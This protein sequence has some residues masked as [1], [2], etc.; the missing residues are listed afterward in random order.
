MALLKFFVIYAIMASQLDSVRSY[1]YYRG[2]KYDRKLEKFQLVITPPAFRKKYIG[3]LH[4]KGVKVIAS[5]EKTDSL[6]VYHTLIDEQGFD[7]FFFVLTPS[8][9][10]FLKAVRDSFPQAVIVMSLSTDSLAPIEIEPF[11]D[12]M[13]GYLWRL[14]STK[15]EG[16]RFVLDPDTAR[17]RKKEYLAVNILNRLRKKRKRFAVFAFDVL[18]VADSGAIRKC[19]ENAAKVDFVE[20]VGP[21]SLNIFFKPPDSIEVDSVFA[22]R[23]DPVFKLPSQIVRDTSSYNIALAINGAKTGY[24]S[25]ADGFDIATVNDGYINDPGIEW[26]VPVNW[27]SGNDSTGHYV[28]IRFPDEFYL[29]SVKIYWPIVNGVPMSPRSY[30]LEAK[31]SE[32]PFWWPMMIAT[33]PRPRKMDRYVF[34]DAYA[35]VIRIYIAPGDG[36]VSTP[37]QLWVSEIKAYGE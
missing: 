25:Q 33:N 6:D 14:Y 10:L 13:D 15:M 22:Y 35:G 20:Y 7:G 36:P 3:K 26:L 21:P 29:D 4:K 18:T 16:G 28:E 12:Y 19:Y 2:E 23:F 8:D 34:T 5:V 1:A 30:R 31:S 11:V 37:F 9:T 17:R 32:R 24:D 27:A